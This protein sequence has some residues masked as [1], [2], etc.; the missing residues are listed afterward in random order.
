MLI[1]IIGIA[2]SCVFAIAYGF[3]S[4][5]EAQSTSKVTQSKIVINQ[6]GYYPNAPKTAF[7]INLT[8]PPTGKVQLVNF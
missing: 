5:I 8:N 2:L 3:S 6:V 7:L 1:F 4:R